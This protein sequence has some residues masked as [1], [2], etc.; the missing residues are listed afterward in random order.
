MV[1]KKRWYF[2]AVFFAFII[3]WTVEVYAAEWIHAGR[4]Y[5]SYLDDKLTI[6]GDGVEAETSFSLGQV[7]D[8]TEGRLEKNFTMMTL[9]EPHNGRYQGVALDY[10]LAQAGLKEEAKYVQIVCADGVSMEFSLEEL[11]SDNYVNEVDDSRLKPI[12][13]YGK[14]GYPLVPDRSSAGFLEKAGNE[15]GPLR[16]MIGQTVEG[17]RNSPKCLQHVTGLVITTKNNSICFSDLG[18][19]YAWAEPAILALA[20]DGVINGVAPGKFAPEKTLTRAEFAKILTIALDEEPEDKFYGRFK[21]VSENSWYAPFIEK[22]A[23]LGF[24]TGYDDGTFRPEGTVNRQELVVMVIRAMGLREEAKE[25]A[26]SLTYR[27]QEKIP[28]WAEDSVAL[29]AEKG[30]LDNIAV[31][32][33]NGTKS[34]SRA[35]AAVVVWRMLEVR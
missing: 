34:V 16:L 14:D 13:A 30:L 7:E 25:K 5:Q 17:E 35:E 24:I 28:A 11:L 10:L 4:D 29:A 20:E 8:M 12:L 1:K 31:G 33:F 2:G 15:G 9:V 22:V 3:M 32:Y 19:F 18:Q 27:D 26:A 23:E 6:S 21:D